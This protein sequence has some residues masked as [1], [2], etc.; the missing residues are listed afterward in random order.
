[1]TGDFVSLYKTRKKGE[2]SILKLKCGWINGEL[3][4]LV[5]EGNTAW[6]GKFTAEEIES[7]C[8]ALGIT[9]DE[10]ITECR[11]AF[12]GGEAVE[13]FLFAVENSRFVWRK[14]VDAD[15]RVKFGS[16]KLSPVPIVQALEEFLDFAFE[17]IEHC[18]Q[19]VTDAKNKMGYFATERTTLVQKLEEYTQNKK[20]FE[21]ILYNKFLCVLNA[22]KER[23]AMLE[24]ELS[25]LQSK[26]Q[27]NTSEI[28]SD[29]CDT[30]VAVESSSKTT[31]GTKKT[32]RPYKR[33]VRQS[34]PSAA[35]DTELKM[36]SNSPVENSDTQ[37]THTSASKELPKRSVRKKGQQ[38]ANTNTTVENRATSPK[39]EES[40]LC[41][42]K[43]SVG[44]M[45]EPELLENTGS[46]QHQASDNVTVQQKSLAVRS[47]SPVA[48]TSTSVI[49]LESHIPLKYETPVSEDKEMCVPSQVLADQK[50]QPLLKQSVDDFVSKQIQ[51]LSGSEG[52]GKA[53]GKI[54]EVICPIDLIPQKIN[55]QSEVSLNNANKTTMSKNKKILTSPAKQ[56]KKFEIISPLDSLEQSKPVTQSLARKDVDSMPTNNS[57][58]QSVQPVNVKDNNS[59]EFSLDTINVCQEP[60]EGS[61][62]RAD[63]NYVNTNSRSNKADVRSVTVS[64]ANRT[65]CDTGGESNHY[66]SETDVDEPEDVCKLSAKHRSFNGTPEDS[67]YTSLAGSET[68][69]CDERD[70][71]EQQKAIEHLMNFSLDNDSSSDEIPMAA[72]PKR[73]RRSERINKCV[74]I[75]KS[76]NHFAKLNHIR[77]KNQS[78]S[79]NVNLV[80]CEQETQI[81]DTQKLLED[82]G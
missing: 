21:T 39:K 42:S 80:F 71:L 25:D 41:A 52:K 17:T 68:P 6:S 78:V 46:T 36:L 49:P 38:R 55:T 3:N 15:T 43:A 28:V 4:I 13:H 22:K 47:A 30:V 74:P 73:T 32:T 51:D 9:R 18:R 31:R 11:Q 34:P 54:P 50:S 67:S 5:V 60:V 79:E 27:L 81:V 8:E 53:I 59:Y 57:L 16:I 1:M 69:E 75:T 24:K 62:G 23:I 70:Q 19:E 76:V 14:E 29:K 12:S 65:N 44:K 82:L 66:D 63:I 56:S 33:R 40:D 35:F 45:C 2:T 48:S 58:K 10:Y 61:A 20:E 37:T 64:S 7:F 77:D 72:L 26:I